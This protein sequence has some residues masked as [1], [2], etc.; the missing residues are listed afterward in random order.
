[1]ASIIVAFVIGLFIGGAVGFFTAALMVA[2]HSAD[3]HIRVLRG[4]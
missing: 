3:E 2:G 4:E 1:M